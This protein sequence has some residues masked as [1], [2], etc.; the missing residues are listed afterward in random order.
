M[1]PFVVVTSCLVYLL[2]PRCSLLLLRVCA[3]NAGR[4]VDSPELDRGGGSGGN[5]LLYIPPSGGGRGG[6]RGAGAGLAGRGRAGSVLRNLTATLGPKGGAGTGRDA[7]APAAQV[8]ALW[9]N[10]HF[11]VN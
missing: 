4:R 8:C 7:T 5:A 6:G 11:C 1:L 9:G 2:L 10:L 3:C